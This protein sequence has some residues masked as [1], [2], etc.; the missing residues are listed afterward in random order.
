M[1]FFQES[2]PTLTV[3][4]VVCMWTIAATEL[5]AQTSEV[6][7]RPELL[8][9][10]LRVLFANGT[11]K[12]GFFGGVRKDSIVMTGGGN[13]EVIS[14]FDLLQI[15]IVEKEKGGKGTLLGVM[16]GLYAGGIIGLRAEQ[17]PFCFSS[18]DDNSFRLLLSLG[19]G[20][21]VGGGIGSLLGKGQNDEITY[22]GTGPAGE[23]QVAWEKFCQT[24]SNRKQDLP[25]HLTVQSAWVQGL[26]EKNRGY[27]YG[28]GSAYSSAGNF[29]VVRKLQAALSI[30]KSIDAGVAIM[31]LGEPSYI[32]YGFDSL[33]RGGAYEMQTTGYYAVGVFKP[34]SFVQLSAPL[35]CD[36]GLGVGFAN[37][38]AK[39]S[40]QPYGY[41]PYPSVEFS[42]INT[43][44][45]S[46][47]LYAELKYYLTDNLSLGFVADY[48]HIPVDMPAVSSL[49]YERKKIGTASVGFAAGFHF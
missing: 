45:L 28:S 35:Q 43:T 22:S 16:F 19:L 3:I 4:C 13:T 34:L 25:F 21:A 23:N 40:S 29:N 46:A 37:V 5:W 24:V 33:N 49:K 30:F 9:Q 7:V 2:K 20:T 42:E 18:S 10:P 26:P 32:K 39:A 41:S 17:Q 36:L 38:S 6:N 1:K 15:A 11:A 14:R 48:A 31:W 12:M 44:A 8:F 47:I 27:G